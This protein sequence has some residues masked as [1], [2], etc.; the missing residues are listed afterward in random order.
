MSLPP[1]DIWALRLDLAD[2]AKPDVLRLLLEEGVCG[3]RKLSE[4]AVAGADAGVAD[5]GK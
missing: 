5:T 4:R 1:A 2:L 3:T